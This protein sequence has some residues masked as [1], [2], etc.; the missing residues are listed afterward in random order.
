M[1]SE[2]I[3]FLYQT[4]FRLSQIIFCF[5]SAAEEQ[6]FTKMMKRKPNTFK[7]T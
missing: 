1:E 7:I 4:L 6:A 5:I 2:E 3:T